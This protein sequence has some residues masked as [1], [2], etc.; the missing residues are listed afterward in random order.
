[1]I[2]VL[3]SKMRQLSDAARHGIS[4]TDG[5][6]ESR[7]VAISYAQLDGVVSGGHPPWW[8][9]GVIPGGVHGAWQPRK[10]NRTY[11]FSRGVL[12][13]SGA[14]SGICVPPERGSA[15]ALPR[16]L[17]NSRRGSASDS[18]RERSMHAIGSDRGVPFQ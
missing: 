15:G 3:L 4:L 6:K 7:Y 8:Q 18:V 13:H 9:Q 17:V 1:M 14:Q 16:E 11:N 10:L 2:S 5:I 12:N